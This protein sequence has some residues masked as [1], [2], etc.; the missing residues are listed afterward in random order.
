M[1]KSPM[2]RSPSAKRPPVR[3]GI[4]VGIA[5][6]G[7]GAVT[8][9][10]ALAGLGLDG[11]GLAGR[12]WAQ[13]GGDKAGGGK[14][15]ANGPTTLIYA[16]TLLAV[17]GEGVTRNQTIVVRNGLIESIRPGFIKEKDA[18]I[19]DLR[20][21]F[22]L[23]GLIDSHVHLLTELG[24]NARLEEVTKSPEDLVVDGADHALKTLRA[25]FTTVAD[26]GGE[27]AAIFALR[28]GIASGKLVG[29][30]IL[31]AG[32]AITPHGGH[33][34][35]HGFRA[36]V[37]ASFDRSNACSG[38]DDCA[39]A[40]REMVSAGAD[41]IKL[42]ATGGVLSNTKAG[43]GQQFTDAELASIAQTAHALGRRATAHAHGKAGIDAALRAG[44]DSIEHGTY[45]DGGSFALYK[46]HNAYLVPTVLAGATVLRQAKEEGWMTDAQR[47]KALI[48]GPLML[49]MLHRAHE[50]GIKIAFG[51]DTGVS[52]HGHN[53]EEFPLWIQAGFTPEEAI[54][55]ATIAAADHLEISDKTGSIVA[56]KAADIIAVKGDPLKRIEEL[57]DV[58]F[59][60]AKGRIAKGGE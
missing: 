41:I 17:P 32:S 48:V 23:P 21:A 30:R 40:V 15:A 51:T 50:A 26:L 55:G 13:V 11:S 58:D 43:L 12:A 35:I 38:A 53:A 14:K 10:G 18:R 2:R 19:V 47:D 46:E 29:P 25:G 56:G 39:R 28:D 7:L 34:D 52:Q 16:G 60:M 27:T 45:S 31:A 54:R 9:L 1:P 49:D 4:L 5:L 59:V 8:L 6:S 57:L 44:I 37:L 22:V 33:A 24:P 42:T 36:D 3:R 20:N